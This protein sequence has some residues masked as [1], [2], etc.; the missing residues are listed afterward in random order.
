[1]AKI[2]D[3]MALSFIEAVAKMIVQWLAFE[4]LTSIGGFLPWASP[5][6]NPFSGGI[7]GGIFGHDIGDWSVPATGLAVIH[8]GEMIIPSQQASQIRSGSA[9]L[10]SSAGSNVTVNF[11][12]QAVDSQSVANLFKANGATIAQIVAGQARNFNHALNPA[13]KT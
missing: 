11:S 3:N 10:G 9:N 12:V 5:I 4:A 6:A 1:M 8:Q 13:W 7:L 2:F